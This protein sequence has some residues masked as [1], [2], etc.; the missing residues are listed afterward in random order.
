MSLVSRDDLLKDDVTPNTQE[1]KTLTI[2]YA[3][4]LIIS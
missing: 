2:S 3:A 4:Y 1:F